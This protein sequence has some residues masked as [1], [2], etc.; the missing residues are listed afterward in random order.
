MGEG[1]EGGGGCESNVYIVIYIMTRIVICYGSTL[2]F[3]IF[4][5]SSR[6]PLT[7]VRKTHLREQV[8]ALVDGQV[9]HC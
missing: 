3:K 6:R 9:S 4:D 2:L 8:I 7:I 5:N 1:R